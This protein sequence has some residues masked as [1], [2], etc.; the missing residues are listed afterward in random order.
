MTQGPASPYVVARYGGKKRK[1]PVAADDA[2]PYWDTVLTFNLAKTEDQLLELEVRD[3]RT[4]R[5]KSV[6]YYALDLRRVLSPAGAEEWFTLGPRPG[7]PAESARGALYLAISFSKFVVRVDR[8]FDLPPPNR[9]GNA[10]ATL[11]PL[12]AAVGAASFRAGPGSS[13][14]QRSPDTG[15]EPGAAGAI[16]RDTYVYLR[17][18]STKV[19][20]A[21]VPASL[22][23]VYGETFHFPYVPGAPLI[24]IE[25]W[26]RG[27]LS[28]SSLG[29]VVL[30]LSDFA[31]GE[32]DDSW[33]R[34]VPCD[35]SKAVSGSLR[36][37]VQAFT[38]PDELAPSW[39]PVSGAAPDDAS[40]FG[41]A[42]H[43]P[44]P[45]PG[46]GTVPSAEPAAA[47]FTTS[48]PAEWCAAQLRSW[49][50][51]L[52]LE[53]AHA[54]V[55]ASGVSP[56][57]LADASTIDLAAQLDVRMPTAKR[58]FRSLQEL[59]VAFVKSAPPEL[60]ATAPS[61]LILAPSTSRPSSLALPDDLDVMTLPFA[62]AEPSD[63]AANGS[64]GEDDVC[65]SS[66]S[67]FWTTSSDDDDDGD[68]DGDGS[69]AAASS[70]PPTTPST[71]SPL[72]DAI[73]AATTSSGAVAL[74]I[75]SGREYVHAS[76]IE[77]DKAS[78]YV[79]ATCGSAKVRSV[80]VA[81][82]FL[83][84][85]NTPAWF[86]LADAAPAPTAA[87]PIGSAFVAVDDLPTN[88]SA[89]DGWLEVCAPS[90]GD[91]AGPVIGGLRIHAV[92]SRLRLA[93]LAARG[94]GTTVGA[95]GGREREL[96]VFATLRYGSQHAET[97]TVDAVRGGQVDWNA[98]AVE[99]CPEP[100]ATFVTVSVWARGSLSNTHL[101]SIR[102]PLERFD[103]AVRH[104]GW[105]SLSRR[106]PSEPELDPHFAQIKIAVAAAAL[107]AFVLHCRTP[108]THHDDGEILGQ[109]GDSSCGTGSGN[110]TDID[111]AAATAAARL[112]LA[113]PSGPAPDKPLPSLPPRLE[114][115][116]STPAMPRPAD[117]DSPSG[118]RHRHRRRRRVGSGSAARDHSSRSPSSSSRPRARTGSK[119]A[120]SRARH[121]SRGTKDAL[122]QSRS[123]WD[124]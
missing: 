43:S 112:G 4:L 124:W 3:K 61:H 122:N 54:H 30:F 67:S 80:T 58:A 77:L 50:A 65:S 33:Y 12:D 87:S 119:T 64:D 17:Y 28:D 118:H 23:P 40:L 19:K 95:A 84:V 41:I 98:P 45:S 22:S 101:G 10:Y 68:G 11:S 116:N 27:T 36:L 114:K 111:V 5:D 83:P 102:L 35:A 49:L 57:Q 38:L 108:V 1:T 39:M 100:G 92:V 66:S 86:R 76:G 81:E 117:G 32:V 31:D 24:D 79:V 56:A 51:S 15:A 53:H 97:P 55:V 7:K 78:T 105:A 52:G 46:S 18:G 13:D 9:T 26:S 75:I 96:R 70:A 89:Y 106:K 82:E 90:D 115:A 47:D 20:G 29:K 74:R 123:F 94:L 121:G 120:A 72:P 59:K 91:A 44:P 73:P 6:G 107:P 63:V 2:Q 103:D 48:H 113:S 110:D 21:V 104:I 99:L 34:L 37:Q 88:G 60:L 8:A 25:L 14:P 71:T 69:S 62:A 42:S 85:Y 109:V 93:L 16:G